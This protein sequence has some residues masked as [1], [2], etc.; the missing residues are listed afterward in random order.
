MGLLP[1]VKSSTR[2]LFESLTIKYVKRFTI[3]HIKRLIIKHIKCLI[4]EYVKP[5]TIQIALIKITT[6]LLFQRWIA[7]P[8]NQHQSPNADFKNLFLLCYKTL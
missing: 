4:I 1:Y 6:V 3:K 8:M 2:K 5:L 7:V